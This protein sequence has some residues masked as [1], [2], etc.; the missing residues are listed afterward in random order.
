V[1]E[2]EKLGLLDRLVESLARLMNSLGLNGTRLHWRWNRRRQRLAEAGARTEI[3]W[4]SA[5]GR[6]KMCRSC[7]ALVDRGAKDCPECGATLSTVRAPGVGRLVTNLLPGVTAATSLIMLVNGFWFVV[8]LMAQMKVGSGDS[9]LFGGFNQELIVRFGSGLSRERLLLNGA[10][11]GGEWWRLVTPIFLHGGMIHFLFNSYLL[12]QLGPVVEELFGTTRYW[13][14]Y[15]CCGIVGSMA[16]QLPR[17]TNTVGASGAIMGLIGL[18]LVHGY[19]SGGALGQAM[20]ALVMRLA[21]YSIILSFMF[22]ID[23]LNHIGGFLCGAGLALIVPQGEFRSRGES[24]FWQFLS[25]AGVLLVLLAFYQ[26][27]AQGKLIAGP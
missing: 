23:H 7:R 20:K 8:M 17:Y 27:A 18:L 11:V 1:P 3:L 10:A 4:R 24:R 5:K 19:R 25:V 15:L 21:L 26:V 2:D 9:S 6:H 22:N 12:M 16:S 13:V 14:I